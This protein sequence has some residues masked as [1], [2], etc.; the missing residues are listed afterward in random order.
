MWL[1]S[2][3]DLTFPM[4][5]RPQIPA[6]VASE[7]GHYVYLYVNPIDGKVFYVGKGK[8]GR[9][10]AHLKADER[11]I[12]KVIREIRAAGEEP[13]IEVLAHGLRSADAAFRIEAAAIDLLGLT[14]R[15]QE[16]RRQDARQ[17]R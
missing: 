7:L 1:T 4:D 9:A 13:R 2:A 10:L 17:A 12:S 16:P 6:S 15:T 11:A 14:N 3:N 5:S 8:G